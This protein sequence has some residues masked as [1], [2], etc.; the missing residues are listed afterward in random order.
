LPG[1]GDDWHFIHRRKPFSRRLR[2]GDRVRLKREQEGE[3]G[4][5]GGE[6]AGSVL[7][8]PAVPLSSGWSR[9]WPL[10]NANAQGCGSGGHS[11]RMQHDD[12]PVQWRRAHDRSTFKSP[13]WQ[14]E[15]LAPKRPP[16]AIDGQPQWGGGEEDINGDSKGVAK[17]D[18]PDELPWQV[19]ARTRFPPNVGV[20]PP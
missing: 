3:E 20:T 1:A 9:C 19:T 6:W 11:P 16:K 10:G 13:A 8:V 5:A 18:D 2:V 17:A 12:E 4:E 14:L 7:H 15:L